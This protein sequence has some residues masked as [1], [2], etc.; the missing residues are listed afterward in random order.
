[1]THLEK[2]NNKEQG[3]V[4][5]KARSWACSWVCGS[6]EAYQRDI[7]KIEQKDRELNEQYKREEEERKRLEKDNKYRV[8]KTLKSNT[9][10][11][12]IIVF[13]YLWFAFCAFG[14]FIIMFSLFVRF[15]GII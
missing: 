5:G 6:K 14:F 9:E 8:S 2:E 11:S 1:M 4:Y 7:E 12:P 13:S 15:L 10:I 3:M